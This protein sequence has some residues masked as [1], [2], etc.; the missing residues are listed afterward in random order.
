MKFPLYFLYRTCKKQLMCVNT[1]EVYLD[2]SHKTMIQQTKYNENSIPSSKLAPTGH[3][4]RLPQWQSGYQQN[5]VHD[6]WLK[7]TTFITIIL[8][9]WHELVS[10]Q[11][12][13]A[14]HCA[15]DKLH[16][17]E[18]MDIILINI[19]N[20]R[21]KKT[22]SRN[23]RGRLSRILGQTW[24]SRIPGL[25]SLDITGVSAIMYLWKYYEGRN[26][27]NWRR[28]HISNEAIRMHC[29]SDV[30]RKF[31]TRTGETSRTCQGLVLV[32]PCTTK[33]GG[34]DGVELG[35]RGCARSHRV[36]LL[37]TLGGGS[38]ALPSAGSCA[39]LILRTNLN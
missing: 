13:L 2:I 15:N 11:F 32:R 6:S 9:I 12:S 30:S 29:R 14:I 19:Y 24:A 37:S 3:R 31:K 33:R 17:H 4:S 10:L 23:S 25:L 1:Q 21:S 8:D 7:S 34:L 28:K 38:H 26:L 16:I 27:W 35:R 5:F 36:L 20:F 18:A 39:P 22:K